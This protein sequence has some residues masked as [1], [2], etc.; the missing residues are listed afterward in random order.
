MV[1]GWGDPAVEEALDLCLSCK[2]CARDCPTG[3]DMATYKS[4]ALHQRY[5]RRPRP[6]SH[7]TLGR[8]PQW[9]R[10]TPPRLA[11]RMLRIGPLARL[12]KAA[13]GVD[14]RRGLPA[15][16]E[17]PLR[18]SYEVAAP[19]IGSYDV[20]VWA[21]SFTDR[22]AADSGRAAVRLLERAGLRVGVIPGPACCALT[23]ITTGQ[24]DQARRILGGAVATLHPYVA[25]GVPVV[26]LE[27]SCLATLRSDAQELLDDP[28]AGEVARGVRSL[29]ELLTGLDDWTPRDLTG[30]EVVAQPHCHQASV[31]GWEADLR[32]AHPG[33]GDGHA[34]GRLLRAGRQLRGGAGALRGVGRDRRARR[35]SPPY[36]R[37]VRGPWCSPTGSPAAPSST[38][39]PGSARCTSRSSLRATNRFDPRSGSR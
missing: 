17:Q 19:A 18:T 34:T 30:V 35:C 26:G 7:Y 10:M 21:D 6:R 11:N 39:S 24:L 33:R 12:A 5:R 32:P 8:L 4:E 31:L 2:G 37:P 9:A 13:A 22:F 28:R 27:P 1:D 16:S 20:W 29:A 36:D 38:T 14:Q 23:W 15:F 3:I 25:S